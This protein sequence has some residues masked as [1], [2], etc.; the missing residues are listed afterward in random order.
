MRYLDLVIL[1]ACSIVSAE[2]ALAQSDS[3]PVIF[4]TDFVMP[5]HDDSM[6]L[7]L[8]LQSPEIEILGITTVAGNE[9]V[10]TAT[11]DVLRMVEI[12]AQAEIPV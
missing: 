3:I 6:A 10:E 1:C 12:A 9:S 5:P 2:V 4:D 11:V 7:M 8:A